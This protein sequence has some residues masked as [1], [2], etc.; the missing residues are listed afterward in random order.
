MEKTTLIELIKEL[1]K[2]RPIFHSEADFQLE[3]GL[4]LREI[5]HRVRLERPHHFEVPILGMTKFELDIEL[6]GEIAIELK[7]K[8]QKLHHVFD[9]EN[10][11]LTNHSAPNLGR[12]DFL[13]DA[14]RVKYFQDY[15]QFKKGFAILL[16]NSKD[17]WSND[18]RNTMAREFSII[19]GRKL[20]KG[21]S[22]RW[23]PQDPTLNSGG[24]KRIAPYSP[25]EIQFN[26]E[27]SWFDYSNI[28]GKKHGV[29]KF[30]VIE[31]G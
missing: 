2:T 22:L 26:E 25:I 15:N 17:Y 1:S 9:G 23:Y 16:T 8:S 3:L 5:G 31:V 28:E 11:K 24:L 13:D 19:K 18:G 29:F 10:F 7:Y 4:K 30:V 21:D 14:R 20:T 6:D 27:I 12:F